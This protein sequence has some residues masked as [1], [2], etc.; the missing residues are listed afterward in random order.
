[1]IFFVY[2]GVLH[3]NHRN[4]SNYPIPR[5]T[6]NSNIS[7]PCH[8][9]LY[10]SVKWQ[11]ELSYLMTLTPKT[12]TA[13]CPNVQNP[14]ISLV[15]DKELR[16][17]SNP[18]PRN[19]TP[20][21]PNT[22]KSDISAP[23]TQN[24]ATTVPPWVELWYLSTQVPRTDIS[25]PITLTS[26]CPDTQNSWHLCTQTFGFQGPNTLNSNISVVLFPEL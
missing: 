6:E 22:Q 8:P 1:M 23:L 14:D 18:I 19:P 24:S 9:E 16:H 26:Q 3:I 20:Q 21:H 2:S 17:L 25:V 15:W 4:L 11:Q 10:I 13:Q 12:L 5:T 7:V